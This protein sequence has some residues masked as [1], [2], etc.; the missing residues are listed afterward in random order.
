MTVLEYIKGLK[1]YLHEE[2]PYIQWEA[3]CL[4]GVTD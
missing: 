2:G 4:Y 1:V 3:I